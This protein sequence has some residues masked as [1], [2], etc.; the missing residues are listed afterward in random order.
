MQ[1]IIGRAILVALLATCAYSVIKFTITEIDTGA[2]AGGTYFGD[3]F[4][5]SCTECPEETFSLLGFCFVKCPDHYI[6]EGVFCA[7]P[8]V[9]ADESHVKRYSIPVCYLPSETQSDHVWQVVDKNGT[10][11]DS[12]P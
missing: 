11:V 8:G 6:K 5:P 4:I 10:I 12:F 2:R 9:V 1:V 3:R 7:P